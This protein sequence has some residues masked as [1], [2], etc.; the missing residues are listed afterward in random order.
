MSFSLLFFCFVR[1]GVGRREGAR[2]LERG[3]LATA[4]STRYDDDWMSHEAR[5]WSRARLRAEKERAGGR[6]M[7]GSRDPFLIFEAVFFS[8]RG[9]DLLDFFFLCFFSSRS[10]KKQQEREKKIFLG[11]RALFFLSRFDAIAL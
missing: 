10:E 6:L 8:S 3:S 4:N 11:R 2:A 5:R 9:H 7:R 1:R